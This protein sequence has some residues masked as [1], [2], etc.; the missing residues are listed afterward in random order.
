MAV[1]RRPSG[2]VS[3]WAEPLSGPAPECV[4]PAAER[5]MDADAERTETESEFFDRFTRVHRCAAASTTL[6]FIVGCFVLRRTVEDNGPRESTLIQTLSFCTMTCFMTSAVLNWLKIAFDD[7]PT[8]ASEACEVRARHAPLECV[9]VINLISMLTHFMIATETMPVT[10]SIFGQRMHSAR[11][12][13]WCSLVPLL[14]LLMHSLDP[15][16]PLDDAPKPEQALEPAAVR[17]FLSRYALASVLCQ[18]A[19]TWLGAVCSLWQMPLMLGL[20]IFLVSCLSFSHIFFVLANSRAA[21]KVVLAAADAT[22]GASLAGL[23]SSTMH[24]SKQV[25]ERQARA[26]QVKS[27]LLTYVC[28]LTWSMFVAVYCVGMLQLVSHDVETILYSAVDV[29]AKCLYSAALGTAHSSVLSP[30]HAL[31]RLL[32][33]E[34]EATLQRRRFLR[35]VMHEVRVPLNAVSLGVRALARSVTTAP[36]APALHD[37]EDN[38]RCDD[39]RL[40]LSQDEIVEVINIVDSSIACMSETLDDVLSFASI[41]EGRFTL[42]C[43]PFMVGDIV[44]HVLAMHNASALERRIPLTS[45]IDA[46]FVGAWLDGDA[47]RLGACVSNFVSNALKFSRESEHLPCIVVSAR[48]LPRPRRAGDDSASAVLRVSVKDNGIGIDVNDQQYLFQA[49]SQIRAGELQQ[50]RG[51]GL[52]LAISKEIVL[53]HGGSIGV[54]SELGKGAE[55]FFEIP[56]VRIKAPMQPSPPPPTGRLLALLPPAEAGA[57]SGCSSAHFSGTPA[58]FADTLSGALALN[59]PAR[60]VVPSAVACCE[61]SLRRD[62]RGAKRRRTQGDE[63]DAV[64]SQKQRAAVAASAKRPRR[65]RALIV[66]DVSS[67]RKLIAFHIKNLGFD[68]EFA[69]DGRRAVELY[70]RKRARTENGDNKPEDRH[71][72]M[73]FDLVLMDSVMPVMNGLDA[74]RLLRVQCCRAVIIGV[75]GNALAEDIHDFMSAGVDAVITKPVAVNALR[76]TLERLG[77]LDEAQAVRWI[78]EALAPR[79]A[80]KRPAD[81]AAKPRGAPAPAAA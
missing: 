21:L 38:Q 55:F 22:N 72:D 80:R 53:L 37:D 27:T 50:G 78:L 68:V 8:S 31:R 41:E 16:G 17:P 48:A 57:L 42:H 44:D 12:A 19:S 40:C 63:G 71:D 23:P 34:Q 25:S 2:Q 35:Y 29:V 43:E 15:P 62:E 69:E 65:R 60:S 7:Q 52:G 47:R 51:S 77:A 28:T 18:T 4:V 58:H 1:R 20:G 73:P 79:C 70:S 76:D 3:D 32:A 10:V 33:L 59:N 74:T 36:A 5:A 13:E 46:C 54:H 61:D 6:C 67:N 45:T 81:A 30:E 9:V 64:S 39:G 11:W 75:T 56:L 24:F 14:M 49:F 66:D 26:R